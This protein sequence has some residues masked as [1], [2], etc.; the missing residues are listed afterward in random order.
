MIGWVGEQRTIYLGVAIN[1]LVALTAY[2]VY[3]GDLSSALLPGMPPTDRETTAAKTISPYS[4]GTRRAVLMVFAI[5]G[6]TAL[7]YEVIWTRQL[8]LFL[9][10]S[11]YAFSGMLAVFLCGIALGSMALRNRLDR[12]ATPVSL[13]GLL[14]LGVGLLSVVNLYLYRPLGGS[15]AWAWFGRLLPSLV[16]VLLVF[17]MTF[18]FGMIF[19]L[20]ALCFAKDPAKTGTSVGSLYSANTVGSIL[21]SLLTGFWLVPHL[22]STRTII[23]LACVNVSLGLLLLALES[24]KAAVARLAAVPIVLIFVAA[25]VG[26]AGKD[27]FL[28]AVEQRATEDREGEPTG[29]LQSA[30]V[31]VYYN[32]EGLEGTITAFKRNGNK[33]LW[34]NGIGVTVL[35]TETKLMAH[36]P[37]MY[38]ENPKDLL[39]IC[40]G[41]GTTF[42][43]A[44]LYPRLNVTAVELVPEAFETFRYYHADAEQVKKKPNV[45]LIVNDG[46]NTLLLSGK[47]YDVISVDPAPPLWSAGTVNLYSDEFFSLCKSRLTPAGVMCLWVPSADMDTKLAIMRTFCEVFEN[48][49]AW[50]GPHGWGS[51]LIAPMRN[52]SREELAAKMQRA[53]AQPMI[54]DDLVEFDTLCS[55]A[56]QLEGLR[57]LDRDAL[58]VYAAAGTVI[59]DDKPYTEFFLGRR[60]RRSRLWQ[61][62]FKPQP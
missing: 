8:I 59:T 27:P 5:S 21:G 11:I 29:A 42:R 55:T 60:L 51:Y 16:T 61:A 13:F 2:W 3:R 39:I 46:R 23:A 37:L 45:H 31:D 30:K 57:W 47:K 9:Q 28:A 14:E 33:Q 4:D 17:P 7:A 50:K 6:F 19:P 36:L 48:A 56:Q 38:A 35:C 24:G 26:A 62:F 25:A 49:T 32:K 53:F 34:I 12:L 22:G 20:A 18:L 52:V 54:H 41:M 43:S 15:L 40:F 44:A 58:R 1:L 10:T